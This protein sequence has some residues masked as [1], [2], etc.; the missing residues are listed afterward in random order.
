MSSDELC[1]TRFNSK[2]ELN[3]ILAMGIADI[4]PKAA[5]DRGNLWNG[6]NLLLSCN[7]SEEMATYLRR[8]GVP[9]LP[10]SFDVP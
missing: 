6:I 8:N 10:E 5:D 3:Q 9:W 2:P 7:G 1:L 4:F